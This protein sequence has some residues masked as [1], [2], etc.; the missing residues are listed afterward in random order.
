MGRGRGGGQSQQPEQVRQAS[1]PNEQ[2][3][4]KGK[5]PQQ[6]GKLVPEPNRASRAAC[7]GNHPAMNCVWLK[8]SVGMVRMT[9][10]AKSGR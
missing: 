7:V 1:D 3:G 8:R 5:K 6:K 4:Q 2:K 9:G 10:L